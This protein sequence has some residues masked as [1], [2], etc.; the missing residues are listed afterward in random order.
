MKIRLTNEQL[1]DLAEVLVVRNFSLPTALRY[2]DIKEE[3]DDP[4]HQT[5]ET[6]VFSCV[7]CDTWRR[8]EEIGEGNVCF[9]CTFA[10]DEDYVF[11]DYPRN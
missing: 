1:K 2:L 5:L 7:G 10:R 4:S 11:C 6:L 8:I 9:R 3:L